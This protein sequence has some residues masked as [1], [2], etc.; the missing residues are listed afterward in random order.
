MYWSTDN[1]I[2]FCREILLVNPYKA[3]KGT[4]FRSSLWEKIDISLCQCSTLKFVVDKR[5]VRDHIGVLIN[6]KK[7]RAEENASG[8][9]PDEPSELDSM[10]EEIVELEETAVL[11]QQV[12][13]DEK[14]DSLE[15]D[16]EMAQDM[17][18][19]AM[20]KLSE[21]TKRKAK[22]ENEVLKKKRR[23]AFDTLQYLKEKTER[24]KG[25]KEKELQLCKEEKE[26]QMK[27]FSQQAD[28][29]KM[30]QENQQEQREDQQ[31][32]RENQQQLMTLQMA[33]MQQQQDQNKAL[34]DVMSKMVDKNGF[35]CN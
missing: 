25:L 22:E 13:D 5:S 29:F 11:D 23:S 32:Q 7:M 21:T 16:R 35:T 1:D 17:R 14:R 4:N 18:H 10:L 20:E 15:K 2:L 26:V 6:K 34:L 19:K 12:V 33:M 9:A 24:E 27:F 28:I 31:Q 3:K 8:I 30:M